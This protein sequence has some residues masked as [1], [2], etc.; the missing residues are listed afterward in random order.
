VTEPPNTEG[1]REMADI[2]DGTQAQADLYG[3]TPNTEH[4]AFLERPHREYPPVMDDQ[5]EP[6]NTE[7]RRTQNW[8]DEVCDPATMT[9][10]DLKAELRHDLDVY[11]R[12]R[13]PLSR[14]AMGRRI[15]KLVVEMDERVE[16]GTL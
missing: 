15:E 12:V 14:A 1:K 8:R 10:E 5:P 3:E 13:D 11:D 9:T 6:P 4:P 2:F 16:M 7:A